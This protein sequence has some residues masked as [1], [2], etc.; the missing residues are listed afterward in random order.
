LFRSRTEARWAV[1]LDAL[2]VEWQYEI[3]GYRL[4]SGPYLP[5][6]WVEPWRAWVEVKP[7]AEISRA[8]RFVRQLKELVKE[9]HA[10]DGYLVFNSPD[11]IRSNLIYNSSAV[12]F[13]YVDESGPL[14][15]YPDSERAIDAYR[16]AQEERFQWSRPGFRFSS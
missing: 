14:M 3:E 13:T 5:D 2:G 11:L 4:R 15:C 10:D 6:F 7:M 12:A 16:R 8:H 1:F 9:T